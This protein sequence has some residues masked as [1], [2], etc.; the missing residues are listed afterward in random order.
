MNR[1]NIEEKEE[2]YRQSVKI[3]DKAAD[4]ANNGDLEGA[5]SHFV[6]ACDLCPE[7]IKAYVNIV[8]C[9]V[10]LDRFS[11][12]EP[13]IKKA[14]HY[15]DIMSQRGIGDRERRRLDEF[16]ALLYT[17]KS[18]CLYNRKSFEEALR[19]A[20]IAL[21]IDPNKKDAIQMK[22]RCQKAISENIHAEVSF[23]EDISNPL[24][25]MKSKAYKKAYKYYQ[26]ALRICKKM[27]YERAL[28]A[29]EQA[30]QLCPEDLDICIDI[31]QCLVC[32]ERY[33]ELP[34]YIRFGI[35][36]D[37][38]Q[39]LVCMERYDELPDY[40]EQTAS[41]IEKLETSPIP[42][43]MKNKCIVHKG[44]HYVQWSMYCYYN[45]DVEEALHFA[46]KAL[47]INPNRYDALDMR[48][49]CLESLY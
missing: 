13:Y 39:C 48:A 31:A 7:N 45:E 22:Q 21:K 25:Y 26:K 18:M 30:Y 35:C 27:Q 40:L 42:N 19:L 14:E 15:I 44:L 47:E 17:Y 10:Y 2:N 32:M 37:I 41:V 46:E 20:E 24:E 11:E 4:L 6:R 3:L 23:N 16:R 1:M 34:D 9:L 38:A 33:D 43:D 8:Q 28:E 49:M 29:F 36:I 12:A 5:L